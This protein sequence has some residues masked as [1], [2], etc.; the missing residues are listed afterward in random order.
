MERRFGFRKTGQIV[1]KVD[2]FGRNDADAW[3]NLAREAY[4]GRAEFFSDLPASLNPAA[5]DE[6]PDQLARH[7]RQIIDNAEREVILVS[8][9]LIPTPELETVVER[10]EARGVNVRVLTN[11]LSSNNHLSAHAAYHHHLEP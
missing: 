4:S 7:L 3:I 2:S 6:L 9:Y 10:I 8:A 1:P 5:P 11:S